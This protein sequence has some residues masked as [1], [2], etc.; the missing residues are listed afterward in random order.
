MERENISVNKKSSFCTW[1]S[2]HIFLYACETLDSDSRPQKRIQ[3]LEMRWLRRILGILYTDHI[4]NE[5]VCSIITQHASHYEDLLTAVKIRKL[6]WYWHVTRSN[7]QPKTIL[8]GTVP[9][10]RRR[11]RQRKEWADNIAKWARR[12]LAEM[13]ALVYGHWEWRQLVNSSSMQCSYDPGGLWDWW[14]WPKLVISLSSVLRDSLQMVGHSMVTLR[15][16]LAVYQDAWI[17]ELV[18]I[19]RRWS[20]NGIPLIG[21]MGWRDTRCPGMQSSL[22]ERVLKW[23]ATQWNHWWETVKVST[24]AQLFEAEELYWEM[25]LKL[26]LILKLIFSNWMNTWQPGWYSVTE[27]VID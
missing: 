6:R 23:Q 16:R 14:W 3:A 21:N 27:S 1:Q 4:T 22:S 12:S 11:G 7:R 19:L 18:V 25:V 2:T 9:G 5:D 24:D 15:E 10:K 8:Q 17:F 13:Q 26:E 20:W